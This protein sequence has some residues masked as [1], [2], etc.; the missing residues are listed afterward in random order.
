MPRAF[1]L[2]GLLYARLAPSGYLSRRLR[3]G[4]CSVQFDRDI[5]GFMIEGGHDAQ[6]IP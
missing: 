6:D 5:L 3:L 1:C 2:L 4:S